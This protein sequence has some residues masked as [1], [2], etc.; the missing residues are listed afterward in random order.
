MTTDALSIISDAMAEMGLNYEFMEWKSAPA[1]PYFVGEYQETAPMSENGEQ[2]TTFIL[3][4]FSRD[5]WQTLE[6]AK[7]LIEN[8]FNRDYGKV[9]IAD[10]GNAVAIFYDNSL[11]IRQ[12][13][14]ELK[15]IQINLTIK[16]WKVN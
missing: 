3:T 11:V 10:S 12:E 7:A 6:D 2:D 13:N 16:E 5:T 1:Y 4:G 8:Y 15:R 9:V 14:S